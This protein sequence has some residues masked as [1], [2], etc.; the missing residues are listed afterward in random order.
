MI[1]MI[2]RLYFRPLFNSGLL[3]FINRASKSNIKLGFLFLEQYNI[4][5]LPVMRFL[6]MGSVG[7]RRRH[8]SLRLSERSLRFVR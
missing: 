7:E 2:F 4:L 6:Y 5:K 8:V 1:V 3:N